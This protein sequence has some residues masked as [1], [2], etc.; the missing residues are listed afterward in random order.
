MGALLFYVRAVDNKVLA[1]LNTI[2]TQRAAATG[3]TNESIDRLLDYSAA[4]PNDGIVYRSRKMVL[5][6]H[7]YAVFYNEFKGRIRSGSHVF[8]A[9]DEPIP[10]WNGSMLTIARIIKFGHVIERPKPN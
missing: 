7:S 6:A 5:A 1:A 4:Y 3:G 8:P 10:G 2:G 9:E